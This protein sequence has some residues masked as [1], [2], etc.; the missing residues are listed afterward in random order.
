MLALWEATNISRPWLDLRA[1][2][3]EKLRRDP[4]LFLV[5]EDAED[6]GRIV[7]AVMGAYDGRRG[8]VYHLAVAPERRRQ[9]IGR[10]LMAALE[11]VMAQMGVSKVNLQVR[12]DNLDVVAFRE[13]GL[14]G[15]ASDEP[16]QEATAMSRIT[17]A[18]L[19]RDEERQIRGCLQ[20]LAW[21]DELLVVVDAR[22]RDATEAIAREFTDRVFTH[23]FAS[24]PAQRN[25]ALDQV[26]T[27][28]VFFVDSD[29]RVTPELA[30]EAREAIGRDSPD[31][32][33]GYWTPRR[34][35]IW[36]RWIRH[37]GWYP[38][39]QLRLLRRDRARYDESREVHELVVLDGP[40]G[41]LREPFVHH[42]YESVGQFLAKQRAYSTLDARTMWRKGIRPRPHNFVLQ[43]L[44]EFKRRYV[45]HQGFR[46]GPHGLLLAA[47]LAYYNLVTYAKLARLARGGDA[48][49]R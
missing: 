38:D 10:R 24:F 6:D 14:P 18:L 3:A 27:E 46:D 26:R 31:A 39:Y 22:T 4:E 45:E 34:N 5:A 21:T 47:L 28:W 8:W 13:A 32:P 16:G 9:G 11:E 20:S 23:P 42:N 30:A 25:F 48:V 49:D 12:A 7:G 37:G 40:D 44:R 43:P 35:I 2:I 15:R 1:E 41:Y 17:G 19:A 33:V 36:G 29:E